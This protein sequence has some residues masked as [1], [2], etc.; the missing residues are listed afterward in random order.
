MV[1]TVLAFFGFAVGFFHGRLMVGV[2]LFSFRGSSSLYLLV[3]RHCGYRTITVHMRCAVWGEFDLCCHCFGPLVGFS[4]KDGIMYGF[5][6]C[7]FGCFL[8][9]IWGAAGSGACLWWGSICGQSGWLS[10]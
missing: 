7:L 2:G 4:A 6:V 8:S 1:I 9:V 5:L 3:A 10:F